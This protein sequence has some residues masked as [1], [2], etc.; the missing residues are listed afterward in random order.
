MA[1]STAAENELR[2][3]LRAFRAAHSGMIV[4]TGEGKALEAWVLMKLANTVRRQM[5][6]FWR[7][8]LRQGDGTT[9]PS[10]STFNL[11][12][13]R[14][15]IQPSS[16]TAP[17]Y[18]LIEHK[19]HNDR[20]FELRGS[21]QW[22]GRSDAKHEIDVSMLPASI[23]EAI[24]NNGGGYPHGLPIVAVECKDKGGFGPLDETRQTLA[25][26]YDLVLVTQPIPGWSCRIFETNTH[27][28][29]GRKSSRYIA[30]FKKG[31]FGIVRAGH[32]Q[33][34]A[35]TLANHYS[36][37][38]YRTVYTTPSEINRLQDSFRETLSHVASF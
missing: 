26:M 1:L 36:I 16:A 3:M 5:N 20:R 18:V 11:P 19:T 29:W 8:S 23:G 10:G 28:L 9:L 30:F 13:Q 6:R 14:S 21:V 31:T 32:F 37:G 24:R 34:G 35:T 22:K 12:N 4:P 25:R 38:H 15:R 2:N 27:T 17:G 7:V 33:S